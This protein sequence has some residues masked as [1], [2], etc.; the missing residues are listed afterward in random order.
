L[1]CGRYTAFCVMNIGGMDHDRQQASQHI[2]YDV[3][4]S[5]SRFFPPSLPV[6]SACSCASPYTMRQFLPT[7]RLPSRWGMTFFLFLPCLH[8]TAG[9]SACEYRLLFLVREYP[10]HCPDYC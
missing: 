3:P 1:F 10:A 2:R 6:C 5:A 7:A 9:L 8:F 4:L